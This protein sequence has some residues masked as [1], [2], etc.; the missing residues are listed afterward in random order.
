MTT[1]QKIENQNRLFELLD[2]YGCRFQSSQLGCES[3]MAYSKNNA[4]GAVNTYV[5]NDVDLKDVFEDERIEG[6]VVT[7]SWLDNGF[8]TAKYPVRIVTFE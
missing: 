1:S 4:A 5:S 8:K 6:M 2:S 7:N 3:E